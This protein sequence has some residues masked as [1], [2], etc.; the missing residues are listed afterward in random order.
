[1]VVAGQKR[2]SPDDSV[3][4]NLG[5]VEADDVEA[6]GEA[7]VDADAEGEVEAST[8]PEA[9]R[10]KVDNEEIAH[11]TSLDEAAVLALAAHS[12]Q[13]GGEEGDSYGDE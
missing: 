6:E 5:E 1:M 7:D 11:D 4:L 12:A 2:S 8:E 13:N 3:A 9:K 10:Q